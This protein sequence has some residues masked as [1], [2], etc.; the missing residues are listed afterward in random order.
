M[1]KGVPPHMAAYTAMETEHDGY[2][3]GTGGKRWIVQKFGG[4]SVGKFPVQIARDIVRYTGHA[5]WSR[6]YI[7]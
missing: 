2:T 3:N 1:F 4:T 7:Y 6:Q 5:F